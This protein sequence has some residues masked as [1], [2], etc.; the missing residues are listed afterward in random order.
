MLNNLFC[1]IF[2]PILLIS[3]KKKLTLEI[4]IPNT[5]EISIRESAIC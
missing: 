1:I 5:E 2:V 4:H 3:C